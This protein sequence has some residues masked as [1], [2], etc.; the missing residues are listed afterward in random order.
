MAD[1]FVGTGNSPYD[2]DDDAILSRSWSIGSSNEGPTFDATFEPSFMKIRPQ[3]MLRTEEEE[4]DD[5]LL[6]LDHEGGGS[7]LLTGSGSSTGTMPSIP[8]G[9]ELQPAG[10]PFHCHGKRAPN[11]NHTARNQLIVISILC[12][13]FMTGEIVGEDLPYYRPLSWFTNEM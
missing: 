4:S 9:T 11:S 7:E 1:V 5:E 13:L 10:R 2:D 12:V 6:L 8:N 3:L